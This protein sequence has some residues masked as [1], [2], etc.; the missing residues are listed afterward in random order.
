[1]VGERINAHAKTDPQ[2]RY[3]LHV[4]PGRTY[5]VKVPQF[6]RPP[7][8]P[9]SRDIAVEKGKDVDGVDFAVSK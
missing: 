6:N 7:D 9:A 8:N 3:T 1:M 4:P 2:G 5:T